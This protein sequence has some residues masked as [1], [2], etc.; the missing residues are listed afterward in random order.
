MARSDALLL[1]LDVL[2]SSFK[3]FPFHQTT[4]FPDYQTA[5]IGLRL[6]KMSENAQEPTP[7]NMTMMQGFEWYVPADQKHWV[8]LEKHVRQ[9][10]QWGIDNIWLPPGCKGSSK[11]GNG[12][13]IYDL[14]DLG[15]F[16]QKGSVGTKWGTKE[17]LLKLSQAA[18]EAGVGLYWDAVLNHKFAADHREKCQAA[19]VDPENRNQSV[20]D[21]YE[22]EAWVGFD[23][24]G[25]GEKYSKMK[26]H[27]YHFGGVDFNA[28]NDRSAIYQIKGE[29][30]TG[31][32][33]TPAVDGEK[34]N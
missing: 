26:Y 5:I 19:E 21:Q 20:S 31:W 29:K 13:D 22:I 7:E 11:N 24:P 10:K 25:R 9:L 18:E 33:E 14:Y 17:E 32:E 1:L 27:W 15:E 23:F 4:S 8:R 30:S 2:F 28:A 34:G 12:Y 16:N 3:A 6:F